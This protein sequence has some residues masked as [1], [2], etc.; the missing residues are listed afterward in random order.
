MRLLCFPMMTLALMSAQASSQ[1]VSERSQTNMISASD[2]CGV[3]GKDALAIRD[4]LRANPAIIERPSGSDRFET[5]FSSAEPTQWTVTTKADAA[6]P[7]VTCV[8]LLNAGGGTEM[9][10]DMRCD[11]SGAQCYALLSEFKASDEKIRSS[12]KSR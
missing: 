4:K 1:V 10:R 11:A 9:R 7:A 3:V 8:T 2:V 5:Y 12:I 6:Y